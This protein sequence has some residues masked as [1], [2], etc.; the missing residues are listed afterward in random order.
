MDG[1]SLSTICNEPIAQ[2]APQIAKLKATYQA[3]SQTGGANPSY[4]GSNGGGLYAN[5]IYGAPFVSPYSIQFNGG[6]QR[7]IARG[8]I[9][10]VD[11]VH[12]ATLKV[13]LLIDV[14]HVGAARFLNK[15]ARLRL[16]RRR[17]SLVRRRLYGCGDQLRDQQ[18]RCDRRLRPMADSPTRSPWV[19]SASD[20]G[21][22]RFLRSE[23]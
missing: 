15:T 16:L 23:P 2:A 17:L 10:S 22:R 18:G 1:V 9:L 12:N 14:N 3:A 7:E 11:Y 19:L 20:T 4:I 13:P 6:I 5:G 21:I 8:T